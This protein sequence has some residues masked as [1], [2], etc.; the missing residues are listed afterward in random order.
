MRMTGVLLMLHVLSVVVWVGGM[1]F[2][3]VCLRPALVEL[4]EPPER[5]RLWRRIFARFFV[6][7][8]WAIVLIVASGLIIFVRHGFAA[9][10][11]NW[12]LMMTSGLVMIVIFVYVAKIL[13]PALGRA[14]DAEDW[15][16]GSL[17]LA[18]IRQMVGTNLILGLLTIAVAT[19]GNFL[20]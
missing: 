5:L 20:F 1:F 3:Y 19:V 15:K 8:W 16:T 12:H 17:A 10:P 11:L 18:R 4:L 7:V 9:A 13:Y 14:V 2:A 6:W